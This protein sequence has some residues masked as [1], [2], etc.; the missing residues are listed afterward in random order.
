MKQKA[1]IADP[2]ITVIILEGLISCVKVAAGG[3][4]PT[5]II[6]SGSPPD[7]SVVV[8]QSI[9]DGTLVVELIGAGAAVYRS[10]NLSALLL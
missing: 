4:S 3:G 5:S 8:S 9:H 1:V 10:R 7:G 2:Y 6:P